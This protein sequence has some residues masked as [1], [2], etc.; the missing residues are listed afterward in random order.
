MNIGEESDPVEVPVPL[1]P[2][3]VPA[4]P[5]PVPAPAGGRWRVMVEDGA[6]GWT[7]WCR[8][9]DDEFDGPA[10]EAEAG[11][12]AER[13]RATHPG[14]AARTEQTEEPP[15]GNFDEVFAPLLSGSARRA[16]GEPA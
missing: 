1:H 6:G 9:K 16:P 15:P 11:E 12:R 13:F 8:W 7:E 5:G 3:D 10:S 14:T 2:D 4:E